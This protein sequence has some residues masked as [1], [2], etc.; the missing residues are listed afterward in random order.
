MNPPGGGG[1]APAE[2]TAAPPGPLRFFQPDR[3]TR[4][5]IVQMM[6]MTKNSIPAPIPARPPITV[7]KPGNGITR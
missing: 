2:A 7:E 5:T 3:F 1:T 4:P 6:P